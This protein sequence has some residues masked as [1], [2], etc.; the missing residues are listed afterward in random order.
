[1]LRLYASAG[2]LL[3]LC[4]APAQGQT[5]KALQA[6]HHVDCG[7]VAPADDWD[8][9][10]IHGDLSGLG[11]EI[12]RAV[13]V[14]ISG[15]ANGLVLHPFPGEPEAF[16]AL[17]SGAVQLVVGVSP[18]T[19]AAMQYGVGFGPPVYYDSQRLLVAKQS[20][21]VDLQ[22]LRNQ[23][24]CAL[25]MSPPERTLR[26]EMTARRI[27]YAL[28][29]HSEQGELDA[30]IAVGKCAGTGMETRLAQSR[31]NFHARTSDFVFLPERFAI[32]PVVPA[33]ARADQALGLVV[34]WTI[35]ALI[36]GEA[37]GIT[38]KNVAQAIDRGDMAAEQ[39][40]GRDFATAQALGLP[41]DWAARVIAV[42]G[43]Y[44]EIFERTTG[45]PY[46]LER[47]LNALWT[48]GGMMAPLPMR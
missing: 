6:A 2:A 4:L 35:A 38:Q 20:G 40:L 30:A 19:T 7:T 42:T 8:G 5:L 18:S 43:N 36:Q 31:A 16:A 29:A 17:K 9:L 27:P 46:Q 45:G 28:Q 34:D 24:I 32:A 39:L 11:G 3:L 25:D 26:D 37:L 1:M 33:Y 15:D 22:G 47:G 12:C 48:Q 14:A 44:G 21:I 10:E 23:L 13:A 41:H